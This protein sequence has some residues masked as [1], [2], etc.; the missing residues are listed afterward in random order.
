MSDY[1]PEKKLGFQVVFASG[2]DPDYPVTELNH[3]SPNTKGWQ[4]PRC[5][6][7][8]AAAP[9]RGPHATP[10]RHGRCPFCAPPLF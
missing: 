4:S 1:G 5:V 3:H 6:R 8:W 2:E 10:A 9:P 7:P